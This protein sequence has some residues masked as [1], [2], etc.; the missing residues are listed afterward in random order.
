MWCWCFA[1]NFDCLGL[2]ATITN[3]LLYQL[4]GAFSFTVESTGIVQTDTWQCL[5]PKCANLNVRDLGKETV[6]GWN[7]L[8]GHP[9]FS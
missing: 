1:S 3:M 9:T 7:G 4:C 6:V 5:G 2:M 8:G